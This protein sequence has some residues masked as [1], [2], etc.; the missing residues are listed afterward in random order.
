MKN[1]RKTF[2]YK[3]NQVSHFS[4]TKNDSENKKMVFNLKIAERVH[5]VAE[6]YV[7]LYTIAN[8]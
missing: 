7:T 2:D 4:F 1:V 3:S 5:N 6:K 8:R